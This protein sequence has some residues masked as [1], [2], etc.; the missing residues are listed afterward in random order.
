MPANDAAGPGTPHILIS[1]FAC[2]PDRGSEP[3]VAW[4]WILTLARHGQHT[5]VLTQIR[6]RAAIT[7][8]AAGPDGAA[9]RGITFHYVPFFGSRPI[10]FGTPGHYLYYYLWQIAALLYLLRTGAWRGATLI[11]HLTYGGINTGSLLFLLPR[12]FMFGP[13]GGGETAPLRLVRQFGRKSLLI[14]MVRTTLIGIARINPVLLLM[15]LR[16]RRIL[17]KTPESAS[18]MI[19][20]GNRVVTT[21]EIGAPVA[22]SVLATAADSETRPCRILFAG[23]L[24]YWKGA[25]LLADA[26]AQLDRPGVQVEVVV[27]GRGVRERAVRERFGRL[28]HIRA[29]VRGAVPQPELFAAY[30]DADLF[31]FP[32]LHDSSGNVVL[33]AMTFGLPVICLNLGGPPLLVGDTGVVVSARD[34]GYALVVD[35]LATAIAALIADPD[36][37]RARASQAQSRAASFSWD[38][39]V[40]NG[41]G[42]L[43]SW[44]QDGEPEKRPGAW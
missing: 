5:S 3:G 6:N 29:D 7:A 24:L 26:L 38:A 14:E 30:R 22:N 12:T 27:I 18:C 11:H 40:R 36:A 39:A 21:V 2:L 15:Q 19:L 44:R 16:A 28:T 35:R 8:W 9:I 10:P 32:S 17:M 43:L 20:G 31:V 41:Y 37:L 4:N 25:E 33:E 34:A 1:A 13:M 42:P 23:R